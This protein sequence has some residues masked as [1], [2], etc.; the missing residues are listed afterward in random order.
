MNHP[1]KTWRDDQD[2]TP[3]ASWSRWR[4]FKASLG[5]EV[6]WKANRSIWDL[7]PIVV[8]GVP[9]LV[10]MSSVVSAIGH[11]LGFQFGGDGDL[12]MEVMRENPLAMFLVGTFFAPPIEELLFRVLPRALGKTIR[13]DAGPMW[14]L[15][16][17]STAIFALAHINPDNP[18]FPLPQFFAGLVFWAVQIRFGFLGS[19]A[20]HAG[21]NG[22]LLLI[23]IV[24][25]NVLH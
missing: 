8:L 11:L 24:A 17:A 25:A 14:A 3:V 4:Q 19:M 5:S 20:L 6:R 9:V 7:V 21:F 2:E 18:T 16:V 22:S 1:P 10:A 13:P 23:V 15:A 12:I